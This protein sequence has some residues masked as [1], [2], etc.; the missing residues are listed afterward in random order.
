MLDS[1]SP[2]RQVEHSMLLGRQAGGTG[3]DLGDQ[4]TCADPLAVTWCQS[5]CPHPGREGELLCPLAT[6]ILALLPKPVAEALR[7]KRLAPDP[8]A[9]AGGCA[10]GAPPSPWHLAC[11]SGVGSREE[12]HRERTEAVAGDA[13]GRE[14]QLSKA[15]GAPTLLTIAASRVA[16]LRHSQS[17]QCPWRGCHQA[18]ALPTQPGPLLLPL[19]GRTTG[20]P[21]TSRAWPEPGPAL[22]SWGLD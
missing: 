18:R 12:G 1:G 20:V 11:I 4:W 22:C 10:E 17:G 8:V 2:Q 6:V 5:L 3:W 9:L 19:G 16:I 13:G 15:P 14:R 21:E 7:W